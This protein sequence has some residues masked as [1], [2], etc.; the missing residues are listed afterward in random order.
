M[1]WELISDATDIFIVTFFILSVV[2]FLFVYYFGGER[3]KNR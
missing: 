1:P 2:T 3:I